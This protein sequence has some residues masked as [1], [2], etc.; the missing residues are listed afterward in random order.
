MECAARKDVAPNHRHRI[1]VLC[2][3]PMTTLIARVRL[4]CPSIYTAVT[5]NPV[6][7]HNDRNATE[8]QCTF[9]MRKIMR[10]AKPFHG[11]QS[12][13]RRRHHQ[14]MYQA[15]HTTMSLPP[16]L[17]N[18][19]CRHHASCVGNGSQ[20]GEP[21]LHERR[22]SQSSGCHNA[23]GPQSKSILDIEV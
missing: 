23:K 9:A 2:W 12:A 20:V 18:G 15:T 19:M 10:K 3:Q 17:S 21:P 5:T 7:I 8:M 6:K 13:H 22:S 16:R 4:K 1:L 14:E 11:R